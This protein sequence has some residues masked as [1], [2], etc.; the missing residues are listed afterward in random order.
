MDRPYSDI[1][2]KA[3]Q[4]SAPNSINMHKINEH[5]IMD[6]EF[7]TIVEA[8]VLSLDNNGYQIIEKE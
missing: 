1:I 4:S 3:L 6:I 2:K 7:D 8:I 5:F